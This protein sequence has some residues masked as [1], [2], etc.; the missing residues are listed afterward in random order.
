M[1]CWRTIWDGFGIDRCDE[2]KDKHKGIKLKYIPSLNTKHLDAITYT[3]LASIDAVLSD[4]ENG[5]SYET[6]AWLKTNS[7]D[8]KYP[9]SYPNHWVKQQ[10]LPDKLKNKKYYKA[11][12]NKYENGLSKINKEMKE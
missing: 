4:I 9:H 5:A 12:N 6:P 7:K 8:Y 2:I 1:M 3:F 11:C 10:Y